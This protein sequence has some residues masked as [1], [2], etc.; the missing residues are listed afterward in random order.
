M[1]KPQFLLYLPAGAL[2]QLRP[3]ARWVATQPTRRVTG[4]CGELA[5]ESGD[6]VEFYTDIEWK[7]LAETVGRLLANHC[8]FRLSLNIPGCPGTEASVVSVC[9]SERGLVT[10]DQWTNQPAPGRAEWRAAFLAKGPDFSL[11]EALAP[12]Y[13]STS[14]MDAARGRAA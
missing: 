4:L 6:V 13:L 8:P 10:G 3:F 11:F 1:V 9:L 7:Y 2:A 14:E 12:T 5:G